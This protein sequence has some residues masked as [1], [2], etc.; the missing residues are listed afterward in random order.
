VK[1]WKQAMKQIVVGDARVKWREAM[2]KVIR[3][4]K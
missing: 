3:G 4:D 1:K 2:A